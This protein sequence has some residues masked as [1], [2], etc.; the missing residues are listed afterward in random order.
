MRFLHTSDWHLGRA[1]EGRSRQSEQEQFVDELCA[2]ARD[3]RIDAVLVAGDVFDSFNPP[4]WAEQLF[5]EALDRLAEGGRRAVVVI[6]G[7][8]DSPERLTAARPLAGRQG[9]YLLGRPEESAGGRIGHGGLLVADDREGTGPGENTAG[10]RIDGGVLDWSGES[11]G[12]HDSGGGGWIM[13]LEIAVPGCDHRAVLAALPYPSE[14]RLRQLLQESLV[15]EAA[16]QRAYAVR[17]RQ[18]LAALAAG[19]QPDTVNIVVSHLFVQGGLSSDSERPVYWVGGAAAV[20]PDD[21]PASAQYIALGHLHRPQRVAAPV[22]C[23]YAGAP[24][25]YSFAEAGQAKS[26]SVVEVRPGQ[27]ARV[28][29]LPLS[30]GRPLVVWQARGLEHVYRWLEEG[31]DTRAWINLEVQVTE[32]LSRQQ[33]QDLRRACDRFVDIRAICPQAAE[34]VPLESRAALPPGELFASFYRSQRGAEPDPALV[35]LFLEILGEQGEPG[36]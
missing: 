17:V 23:R 20:G 8:H 14:A 26:V 25:A 34:Q 24:L 1:L 11:A 6:A 12:E 22:P 16:S 15:D 5:Y 21:L 2:M 29:E 3:Q 28:E 32:P 35:H 7:N 30:C 10:G 4:A 19:F 18:L 31:R 36:Q 9:I 13:P 27:P 33:I